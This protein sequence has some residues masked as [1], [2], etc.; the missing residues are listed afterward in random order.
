M[1]ILRVF[2]RVASAEMYD[3]P[4]GGLIK[5]LRG[6]LGR[7]H[8]PPGLSG[9]IDELEAACQTRNDLLHALPV[10]D[11]HHRRRDTWLSARFSGQRTSGN[12][13]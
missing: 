3:D 2:D 13:A 4:L 5:R 1:P 12:C 10:K 7:Y 6:S 9:F 11:G 8:M